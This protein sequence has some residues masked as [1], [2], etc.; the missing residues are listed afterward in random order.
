MLFLRRQFQC[1]SDAYQRALAVSGAHL[2]L[3]VRT[4]FNQ[5]MVLMITAHLDIWKCITCEN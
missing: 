1:Y 4:F 2:M 5:Q 3:I